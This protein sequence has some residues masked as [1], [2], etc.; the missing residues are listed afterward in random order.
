VPV[1]A[2][3]LKSRTLLADDDSWAG[4]QSARSRQAIEYYRDLFLELEPTTGPVS[5]LKAILI[6]FP[7]VTHAK[8]SVDMEALQKRLKPDFVKKGLMIGQFYEGCAESGLWN[9]SFQPLQSPI[10]LLAIRNMV[11]SDFLFLHGKRGNEGMLISY[12][13]RF[14]THIPREVKELMVRALQSSNLSLGSTSKVEKEPLTRA[15][16]VDLLSTTTI[17]QPPIT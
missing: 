13:N 14:G 7:D 3:I 2:A 1:H 15:D 8:A 11:P 10:P 5:T 6:L 17:P 16:P 12:L 9:D 4:D